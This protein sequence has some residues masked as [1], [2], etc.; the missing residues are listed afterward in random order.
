M[1]VSDG[2]LVEET[3]EEEVYYCQYSDPDDASKPCLFKA[4]SLEELIGMHEVACHLSLQELQELVELVQQQQ[5]Q[6]VQELS[7]QE[8][9]E[10]GLERIRAGYCTFG[11]QELQGMEK[12]RRKQLRRRK[13]KQR[14]REQQCPC[15]RRP[16]GWC[17][18]CHVPTVEELQQA[19]LAKQE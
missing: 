8:L 6:Q 5:P 11:L 19:Q 18:V 14:K 10:L 13:I 1:S 9:R 16:V 12:Q 17:A 4:E 2:H 15:G 7:R 3:P